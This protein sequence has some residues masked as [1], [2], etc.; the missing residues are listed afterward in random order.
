[1]SPSLRASDLGCHVTRP[2]TCRDSAAGT[3]VGGSSFA[4]GATKGDA[5]FG[6]GTRR[7]G[8]PSHPPTRLRPPPPQLSRH[9]DDLFFSHNAP[10]ARTEIDERVH[11]APDG[12]SS[13]G[14]ACFYTLLAPA[15]RCGRSRRAGAKSASESGVGR[16]GLPAWRRQR[17]RRGRA[18]RAPGHGVHVARYGLGDATG[19]EVQMLMCVYR[20]HALPP[21]RVAQS[22]AR[23]QQLGH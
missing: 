6:V 1:M 22:R 7:P 18:P 12:N 3:V 16:H 20:R 17:G 8:R 14:L 13:G 23:A 9:R 21:A 15:F 2:R 4:P 19:R 11:A 5:R 10:S